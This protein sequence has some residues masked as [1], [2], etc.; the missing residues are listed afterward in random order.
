M[1]LGH[2]GSITSDLTGCRSD[3]LLLNTVDGRSAD[4]I[5]IK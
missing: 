3:R 2:L 1:I 4:L 5:I